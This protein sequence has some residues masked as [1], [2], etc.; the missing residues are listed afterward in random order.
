MKTIHIAQTLVIALTA[1]LFAACSQDEIEQ[2]KKETSPVLRV[3]VNHPSAITTRASV[4]DEVTSFENG[5][6]I[7]VFAVDENGVEVFANIPYQFDGSDWVLA[8]QNKRAYYSD[9][10]TYFAYYPYQEKEHEYWE[11]NYW[12]EGAT[13]N[14]YFYQ[15]ISDWEVQRDQSTLKN[16]NASDLM[17]G[18]GDKI[19]GGSAVSFS[20]SHNMS[21]LVISIWTR[22]RQSNKIPDISDLDSQGCFGSDSGEN[23]IPYNDGATFRYIGKPGELVTFY[24]KDSQDN[25]IE[26]TSTLKDAGY[27]AESWFEY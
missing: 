15:L 17:T 4:N 14:D 19:S 3:M 2:V 13:V 24:Y 27:V 20:L 11:N 23:L 12:A 16:Y 8:D 21:L 9:D 25:I 6:M 1:F 5:D 10:Y 7:G 26:R 22:G 18:M